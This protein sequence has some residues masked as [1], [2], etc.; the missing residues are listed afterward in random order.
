MRSPWRVISVNFIGSLDELK[1]H[2]RV[3]FNEASQYNIA[4][5]HGPGSNVSCRMP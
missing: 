1:H 2:V 4:P 3:T 5:M